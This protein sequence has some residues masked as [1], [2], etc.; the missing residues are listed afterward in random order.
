MTEK[1]VS[2]GSGLIEHLVIIVK[3][4]HTFDNYFGIFPGANGIK[5]A[6]SPNPPPSD[7]DHRHSAWLTRDKTSVRQQFVEADTPAYFAYA[8]QFTLCDNYFTEVAGPS[9]PN[10]L[11]LIAAD[12]PFIDN[13]LDLGPYARTGC[14]SNGQHSHVSLVRYCETLFALPAL[15]Q[16]D[17]QADDMADCFDYK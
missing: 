4:N 3:E 15:N 10:H 8:R 1:L 5:L 7:P 14:V 13:P 2:A 16:L 9:T 11:M 17:R 6:R 12:S